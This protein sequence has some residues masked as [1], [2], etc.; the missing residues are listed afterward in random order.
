MRTRS[1]ALS[2][3]AS[4]A[5]AFAA[6]ACGASDPSSSSESSE[7]SQSTDDA[8]SARVHCKTVD[9]CN[10]AFEN[11][12]WKLASKTVDTCIQNHD[13]AYYC[14]ACSAKGLCSFHAGF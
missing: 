5:F 3:L 14:M 6:A 7:P 2:L 12:T 9:D 1:L 8:L 11:G 4:F 13:F 10:T